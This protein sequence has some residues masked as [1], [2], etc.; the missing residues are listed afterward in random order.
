MSLLSQQV[1]DI[2]TRL[3]DVIGIYLHFLFNLQI[4]DHDNL[5]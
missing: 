1:I 2:D 5:V 3:K 4:L